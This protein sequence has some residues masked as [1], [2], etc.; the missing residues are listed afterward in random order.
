MYLWCQNKTLK[1]KFVGLDADNRK[2]PIYQLFECFMVG[3]ESVYGVRV[4]H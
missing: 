4:R 2:L 3:N 1:I